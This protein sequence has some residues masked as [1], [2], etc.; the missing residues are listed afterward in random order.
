MQ[1]KELIKKVHRIQIITNRMV[2]DILAGEYHSAFKGKG[3]EF[4]EVREYQVGDDIRNIDWNVTAR[5]GIPHVK[6]FS[7]EREL[8]I[9]FVVDI[10]P[11][12]GFGTQNRTKAQ[13]AVEIAAILAFAAIKN[14]DKVGL[15]LFSDRIEKFLPPRKGRYAVMRIIREMLSNTTEGEGTDVA[16]ALEYLGRVQRRK[17][18]VFL[19]SDFLSAAY[20]KSIKQAQSKHDVIAITSH[21]PGEFSFPGVG[22]VEL[23]DSETGERIIVDG[24]SPM[25]QKMFAQRTN[26]VKKERESLFK[27][28]DMDE[29]SVSTNED[30]LKNIH[31][32]FRKR[33]LGRKRK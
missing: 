4:D 10:S 20:E 12:Q 31:Q 15:I 23:E 32:L 17:A 19:I 25:L 3:M 27:R 16:M 13:L 30:Y 6:R 9:Y 28:I 18:V 2:N 26:K 7:E 5:T 14:N 24:K 29:L 8:T 22:L 33:A 11:S 1:A 21:D